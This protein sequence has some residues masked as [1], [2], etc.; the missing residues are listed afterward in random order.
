MCTFEINKTHIDKVQFKPGHLYRLR[1]GMVGLLLGFFTDPDNKD[2]KVIGYSLESN[3][4]DIIMRLKNGIH[5]KYAYLDGRAFGYTYEFATFGKRKLPAE[6]FDLIRC[7]GPSR[8]ADKF[9]VDED[10]MLDLL[11]IFKGVTGPVE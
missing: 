9:V 3:F 11:K 6:I 5:P 4:E 8:I 10:G 2:K 1:N 7:I